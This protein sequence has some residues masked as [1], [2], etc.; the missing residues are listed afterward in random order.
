MKYRSLLNK[1]DLD[2]MIATMLNRIADEK[3]KEKFVELAEKARKF[4]KADVLAAFAVAHYVYGASVKLNALR[5]E[6]DVGE[7]EYRAARK[8]LQAS[9]RRT[10][11]DIDVQV[12]ERLKAEAEK[13]GL[14][15]ESLK[16]RY[17]DLKNRDLLSGKTVNGRVAAVLGQRRR[18]GKNKKDEAITVLAAGQGEGGMSEVRHAPACSY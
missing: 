18:K 5:E 9:E 3:I 6:F 2:G 4:G 8:F 15:F 10:V 7:T 16:A 12:L 17:Y 14:D 1:N 13:R 11:E